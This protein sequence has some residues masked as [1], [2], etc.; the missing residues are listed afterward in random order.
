[1]MLLPLRSTG[2][3]AGAPAPVLLS[4]E[5]PF[6]PVSPLLL[7]DK[8]SPCTASVPP[9]VMVL[10]SMTVPGVPLLC[11]P[12]PWMSRGAVPVACGPSTVAYCMNRPPP[13][14]SLVVPCSVTD[15]AASVLNS[16]PPGAVAVPSSCRPTPALLV[17][18]SRLS[19]APPTIRRVSLAVPTSPPSTMRPLK[20][21]R[22]LP[23]S[24]ICEPVL[25]PASCT[26]SVLP[27]KMYRPAPRLAAG[28]ALRP[29]SASTR[30]AVSV[31][32]STRRPVAVSDRPARRIS[33]AV[34]LL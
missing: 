26:C 27:G 18:P 6:S 3:A 19:A 34:R 4:R 14:P 11:R 10:L 17:V 28:L 12:L 2:P 9:V 25:L 32:P 33:R 8:P 30:S 15:V 16:K 20:P 21:A 24:A 31:E 1:M 13:V 5:T 23:D 7:I 22:L 29:S